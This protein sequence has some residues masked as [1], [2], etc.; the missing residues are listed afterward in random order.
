[1][2]DI[3][4]IIL[5]ELYRYKNDID[6]IKADKKIDCVT[7]FTKSS[8]ECDCINKELCNN[9]IIDNMSSGNLYYLNNAI[10]TEYG[11][12]LFIKVRKHDDNFNDF[13]ISVDFI[14]DN[15]E[16]FKNNINNPVIKKYDTFELI[17][18]KNER[19]IINVVSIGAKEDYKL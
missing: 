3:E 14:V 10:N 1:M 12:L 18:L 7:I 5:K 16:N 15:Y 8:E 4:E 19:S 2:K 9:K 11:D 13:R 17:Q 6:M